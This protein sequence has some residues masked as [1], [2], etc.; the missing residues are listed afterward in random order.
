MPGRV[1]EFLVGL[2]VLVGMVI[3]SWFVVY[4]IG[5]A[6]L[7]LLATSGLSHWY[8][9]LGLGLFGLSFGVCVAGGDEDLKP[10]HRCVVVPLRPAPRDRIKAIGGGNTRVPAEDRWAA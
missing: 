1:R 2:S 5:R 3:A 4:L 9:L 6:A 7:D 8:G 10:R